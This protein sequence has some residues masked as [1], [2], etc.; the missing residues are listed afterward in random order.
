MN[1][2]ISRTRGELHDTCA[3][4]FHDLWSRRDRHILVGG[5]ANRAGGRTATAA[6]D[7]PE[8][9]SERHRAS[10]AHHDDA[11]FRAAAGR[12]ESG[13]LRLLPRRHGAAVRLR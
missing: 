11:G 4:G 1:R 12:A 5:G 6:A 2:T 7:E 3:D 9:L 13:W 8:D 10:G